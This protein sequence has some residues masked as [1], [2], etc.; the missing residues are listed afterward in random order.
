VLNEPGSG[1]RILT[2]RS[3]PPF[4]D[5]LRTRALPAEE[6]VPSDPVLLGELGSIAALR[7]RRNATAS[8]DRL[9]P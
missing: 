6:P 3:A 2:L 1:S 9:E 7:L 4:A 8:I 5:D